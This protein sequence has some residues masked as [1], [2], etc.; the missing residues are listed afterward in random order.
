M[1]KEKAAQMPLLLDVAEEQPSESTRV[2][3]RLFSAEQRRYLSGP[4]IFHGKGGNTWAE[5]CPDWLYD[6]IPRARF[7]QV[8]LESGGTVASGLATLEEITAYLMTASL[9]APLH[10]DYAVIYLWAAA[11]VIARHRGGD[12]T[13]VMQMVDASAVHEVDG[14]RVLR[15]LSPDLQRELAYLRR[16]IRRAVVRHAAKQATRRKPYR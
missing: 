10:H 11:N 5:D 8:L 13:D 15:D 2:D 12:P 6:A 1:A 9:E 14:R 7:E 16:E 4:I 3:S